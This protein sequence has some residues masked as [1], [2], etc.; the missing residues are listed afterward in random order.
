MVV[1][2]EGINPA[3]SK[4]LVKMLVRVFCLGG[5][6]RSRGGGGRSAGGSDEGRARDVVAPPP[7]TGSTRS[8]LSV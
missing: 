4:R 5:G 6:G 1:S 3:V 8:L 7:K 2:I